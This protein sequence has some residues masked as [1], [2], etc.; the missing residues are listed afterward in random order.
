M[1]TT[2]NNR[3]EETEKMMKTYSID[4]TKEDFTRRAKKLAD[5]LL[6]KDSS[7]KLALIID[8]ASL[9]YLTGT[10]QEG[11]ALLFADGSLKYFVRRSY[12][13]ALDESPL[14]DAIQPMTSYRDLVPYLPENLEA[15]YVEKEVLP[16][17]S[18]ERLQ[19]YLPAK[20]WLALDSFMARLRSVKDA[21][22]IALIEKAGSLHNQLLTKEVPRLLKEG[23]S[24]AELGMAIFQKAV[25]IGH[26]G[27]MKMQ[28]FQ[29]DFLAGQI[30]FGENALYPM[31]FDGPGGMK[32]LHPAT[33]I[34]GSDERKLQK[35]DLVFV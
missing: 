27:M 31:R 8:S 13:R 21:K 19:K 29:V 35:G 2:K 16:L 32:G 20:K 10:M 5:L 18:F 14:E 6:K 26:Y 28:M 23:M 7:F 11:I 25:E 33:P 3:S 17:V 9:Y 22:E 12:E 30:A 24:E 15:V 1:H 34:L 4:F